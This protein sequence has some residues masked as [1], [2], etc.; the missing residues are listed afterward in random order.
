[1]DDRYRSVVNWSDL[2]N[3]LWSMIGKCFKSNIEL[4]RFRSTCSLW[5]RS[6]VLPS[7]TVPSSFT[8]IIATSSGQRLLIPTTIYRIEL[9][10]LSETLSTSSSSS[11]KAWLIKVEESD[12]GRLC[13]LDPFAYS[14]LSH[15][16][17]GYP[18]DPVP[19][20]LNLLN[21]R[22]VELVKAYSMS[23]IGSGLRF[24]L[25]HREIRGKVVAFPNF[26]WTQVENCRFFTVSSDGELG[27]SKLG[28]DEW[29]LVDYKNF[30]YD[31]I[32]VHK[33]QLYVV[34]RWG[35]IYWIDC[36]S[37]NVVQFSPPLRGLGKKNHLVES[38][39][40]LYVVDMNVEGD[41]SNKKRI[42]CGKCIRD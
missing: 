28:D 29:T 13:L 37:L 7:R 35:I 11:P 40:S 32:I 2:P 14:R 6:S 26:A 8:P 23:L 33:D 22:F 12:Y 10:D 41:P 27:F 30:Y 25:A 38:C 9:S 39:G 24:P 20:V 21:F 16:F 18:T 36:S 34:D 17:S 19:K 5:R 31:D 15:F 42:R 3:E 1:M 4:L